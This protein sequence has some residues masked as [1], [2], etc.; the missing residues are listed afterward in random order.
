[1]ATTTT[2]N[3]AQKYFPQIDKSIQPELTVHLQRIYTAINDHDQAIVT[4]NSKVS[5]TSSTSTTTSAAATTTTATTIIQQTGVS[6][7]NALTGAVVYFPSLG[8]VNDQTGATAYTTQTGD[9]GALIKLN[10]SSAIAVTLNYGVTAPWFTTISNQ[11]TGTATITPSQGLINGSASMTLAAGLFVTIYFDGANWEGDSVSGGGTGTITGVTAGTGLTGGGTSG[12]VTLALS[13]PVSVANGGNGTATPSLVA[14]SNITITGSWPDQ[15]IAASSS[16][17]YLKGIV[18]VETGGASGGTFSGTG[19][20]TGVTIDMPVAAS[21]YEGFGQS[22][23]GLGP[24]TYNAWVSAADTVTVQ[25]TLPTI[26][27]SYGNPIFE[28]VV[29][30]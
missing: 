4:L 19:T 17:A 29:F 27:I 9:N 14:G 28:V 13:T 20:V 5:G 24:Y 7:F 3:A 18:I 6:S 12:D 30:P 23:S 10:S 11:G 16:T 25:I 15:T 2:I 1:M 22:A 21:L 26:S 8:A